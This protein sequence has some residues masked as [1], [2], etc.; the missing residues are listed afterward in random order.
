MTLGGHLEAWHFRCSAWCDRPHLQQYHS[1]YSLG[2][3]LFG[4]VDEYLDTYHFFLLQ[5]HKPANRMSHLS[6]KHMYHPR[7]LPLY[8]PFP[9]LLLTSVV[10]LPPLPRALQLLVLPPQLRRPKSSCQVVW[11]EEEVSLP[12]LKRRVWWEA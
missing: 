8:P 10:P 6:L 9:P 3:I 11:V 5:I 4:Y 12:R 7:C 2:M 1:S